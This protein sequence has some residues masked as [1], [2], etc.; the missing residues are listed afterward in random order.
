MGG[1]FALTTPNIVVVN[2][3]LD[4]SGF[5]INLFLPGQLASWPGRGLLRKSHCD[6]TR[7]AAWRSQET[8]LYPYIKSLTN[9]YYPYVIA[10]GHFLC[11]LSIPE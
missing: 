4:S 11:K 1:K 6:Y 5:S 2:P 10:T 9:T 8:H 7:E 3:C